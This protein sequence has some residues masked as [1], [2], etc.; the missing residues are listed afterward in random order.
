[1]EEV[2]ESDTKVVGYI[3][4]E[5]FDYP[6]FNAWV[7]EYDEDEHWVS[8]RYK[9]GLEEEKLKVFAIDT[10]RMMTIEGYIK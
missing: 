10:I 9:D 5:F 4:I 8:V 2:V 7:L 6:K 1:M 3:C